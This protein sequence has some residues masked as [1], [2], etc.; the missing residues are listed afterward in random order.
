V[1][2]AAA[3]ATSSPHGSIDGSWP[4]RSCVASSSNS[5]FCRSAPQPDKSVLIFM[6]LFIP[7]AEKHMLL[8]C[9]WD[10]SVL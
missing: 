2:Q 1:L 4:A 8:I 9:V 3:T 5:N 10:A 7:S 6:W